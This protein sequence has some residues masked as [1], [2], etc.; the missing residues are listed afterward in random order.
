MEFLHA[1]SAY[2]CRTT[3]P[4][5]ENE[6][7][8]AYR[9]LASQ[10]GNSITAITIANDET[11]QNIIRRTAAKFPQDHLDFVNFSNAVN[12]ALSD[13]YED[14][15]PSPIKVSEPVIEH[16]FEKLKASQTAISSVRWCSADF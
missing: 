7:S 1:F 6:L 9:T 4:E 16:F 11:I 5:F 13:K 12:K 3:D 2:I 15:G 14:Y 10:H 8:A